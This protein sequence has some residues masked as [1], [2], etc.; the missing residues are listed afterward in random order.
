[1]E[2]VNGDP[3]DSGNV[4]A[5]AFSLKVEQG[6]PIEFF[7][8]ADRVGESLGNCLSSWIRAAHLEIP[9]EQIKGNRP[10]TQGHV[11]SFQVGFTFHF[12]PHDVPGSLLPTNFTT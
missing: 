7:G 1:M 2:R 11:V 12:N 9:V 4:Q 6:P 10:V 3:V 5:D 8:E